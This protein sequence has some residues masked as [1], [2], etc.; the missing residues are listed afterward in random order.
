MAEKML[1]AR[2]RDDAFDALADLKPLQPPAP[3][4][5]AVDAAIARLNYAYPFA[6]LTGIPA[7]ATVT[8]MSKSGRVAPAGSIERPRYEVS[9]DRLLRL[10]RVV[11]G[12]QKLA[13]TD[14]GSVTHAVLQRIDLSRPCDRDDLLKQMDIMAE[15]RFIRPADIASVNLDAILWLLSTP[16]AQKL[17]RNQA[18]LLREFDI[19]FPSPPDKTAVKPDDL[20]DQ[21]MVRGRI[22]AIVV[23]DDGLTLI[24]YKTDRITADLIPQRL[25]FYKPQ[26]D[27]YREHLER[28]TGRRVKDAYLAFLT[29]RVIERV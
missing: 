3:R 10:P 7:S 28:L 9:F 8:G 20:A 25:T 29:P 15:R 11:A 12:E 26:L 23:E 1:A 5:P 2:T 27:A 24:D 16:L 4:T 14:V 13:P 18:T 17:K 6:D 21:V 22:D 19:T